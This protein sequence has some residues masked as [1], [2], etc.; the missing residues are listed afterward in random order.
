MNEIIKL[1][2]KVS[3][4]LSN[5]C[6][7][8]AIHPQCPA[9]KVRY[10]IFL[11]QETILRVLNNLFAWGYKETISWYGYNE[12]T[13]DPR[14]IKLVEHTSHLW[15]GNIKQ[16]IVSNGE[17]LDQTLLN[18]LLAAGITYFKIDSYNPRI[19]KR[20]RSFRVKKKIDKFK[21]VEKTLDD[22]IDLYDLPPNDLAVPCY[23]PYADIQIRCS[24][25]ITL[26]VIDWRSTVVFGDLNLQSFEE[27]LRSPAMLRTYERLKKGERFHDVCSRCNREIMGVD[28]LRV[29]KYFKEEK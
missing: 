9:S 14:L 17:Y 18:E 28:C 24:G 13:I 1:I 5:M 4:E 15:K 2:K 29:S 8:A 26:C 11:K 21:V 6:N 22:R 12:P 20:A 19:F 3:F 7:Y 25:Q 27:I 10:P 16:R 23:A